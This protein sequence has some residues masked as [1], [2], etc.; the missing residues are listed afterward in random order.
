MILNRDNLTID[1]QGGLDL[2]SAIQPMWQIWQ[3]LR[4]GDPAVI[5]PKSAISIQG[6]RNILPGIVLSERLNAQT[7][8]IRLAGSA[9]EESVGQR[10]AG[11]NLVDLSPANQREG[12]QAIYAAVF[13]KPCGFHI[14]EVLRLRGDRKARLHALVLPLS[15]KDGNARFTIGHYVFTGAG[16]DDAQGQAAIEHRQIDLFGHID[17]GFGLP[18]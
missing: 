12:I 17:L 1:S 6:L 15:D 14:T 9:V 3:G 11:L 7:I 2:P 10:L 8:T 4:N 18:D 5:P 16:Y 13:S